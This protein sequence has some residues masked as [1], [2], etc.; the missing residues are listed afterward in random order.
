MSSSQL[1]V[2]LQPADI[3]ES[4]NR[5]RDSLNARFQSID[6]LAELETTVLQFKERQDELKENVC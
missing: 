2:L 5:A 3:Q 4:H 6:D 1:K